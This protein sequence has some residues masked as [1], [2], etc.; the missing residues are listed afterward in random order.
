MKEIPLQRAPNQKMS[1]LLGG[2][3]WAIEVKLARHS[4]I[5]TAALEME[6]VGFARGA[7]LVAGTRAVSGGQWGDLWLV[8]EDDQ[9]PDWREFGR[10]Q[11][12]IWVE[13]E[14]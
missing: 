2:S 3:L 1:V 4:M 8:T 9:E 6:G 12:L 5:I 13:P 10:T 7:R 14:S 11:S